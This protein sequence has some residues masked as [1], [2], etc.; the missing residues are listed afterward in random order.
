[1]NDDLNIPNDSDS[2]APAPDAEETAESSPNDPQSDD[3]GVDWRAWV[4][5]L[6]VCNPFFL[7]SAALLLLGVNRLSLDPTILGSER[8]NLLFNFFALQFYEALLVATA[9]W[10]ARRRIWYDP[11]LLVVMENG[12]VLAPFMLI[13]QALF[14]DARLARTLVVVGGIIAAV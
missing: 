10:L 5:R 1:M 13:S 11:A 4:R 7:C 9:V 8:S 12:L 6:L 3:S 14:L 2:P